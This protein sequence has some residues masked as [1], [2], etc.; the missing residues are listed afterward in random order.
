MGR[1]RI[2]FGRRAKGNGKHLIIVLIL[3]EQQ[4]R[5]ALFVQKFIRRR[6]RFG[7]PP[8]FHQ[9][10]AMDLFLDLHV[11]IYPLCGKITLKDC[12]LTI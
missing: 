1:P 7:N 5:P 4:P 8:R 11:N 12:P 3:K 6:I 9:S 10:K 2:I